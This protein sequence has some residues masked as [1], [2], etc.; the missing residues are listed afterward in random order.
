MYWSFGVYMLKDVKKPGIMCRRELWN[1][2]RLGRQLVV[3][4]LSQVLGLW[5]VGMRAEMVRKIRE[6]LLFSKNTC[7]PKVERF[8]DGSTSLIIRFGRKTDKT[9][10]FAVLN[11]EYFSFSTV[12]SHRIVMSTEHRRDMPRAGQGTCSSPEP[13]REGRV[14]QWCSPSRPEVLIHF[15]TCPHS[16]QKVTVSVTVSLVRQ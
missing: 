14:A 7:P 10:T 2:L 3:R 9:L 13:T 4:V 16:P 12:T 8:C 11:S 1:A 6:T 5:G 15:P